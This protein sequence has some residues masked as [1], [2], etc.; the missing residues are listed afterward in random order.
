MGGDNKVSG[1]H[2]KNITIT[3]SNT[4]MKFI[5]I[6]LS[7]LLLGCLLVMNVQRNTSTMV[8]SDGEWNK[9]KFEMNEITVIS[10]QKEPFERTI[11]ASHMRKLGF[12][13]LMHHEEKSVDSKNIEKGETSKISGKENG[14]LNKSFRS[15]FQLQKSDVHE[16]HMILRRKVSLRDDVPIKGRSEKS[17]RHEQ[18]IDAAKEIE[19]LMYK[20]YNNKGKPSHR[21]PINNP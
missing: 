4:E 6:L 8:V 13:T 12:G 10:A 7:T 5:F 3:K 21:P 19:S 11:G 15:L 2:T 20:D 1:D 9:N 17:S 14:G 18:D 16:K